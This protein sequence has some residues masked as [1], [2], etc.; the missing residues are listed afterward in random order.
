MISPN[1]EA[2]GDWPITAGTEDYVFFGVGNASMSPP[3]G[4][5]SSNGGM[6]QHRPYKW[7]WRRKRYKA[8]M[9]G[10]SSSQSFSSRMVH[11]TSAW[12][13]MPPT[14]SRK[15]MT[16]KTRSRDPDEQAGNEPC[17]WFS[18]PI[19]WH[20]VTRIEHG[21]GSSLTLAWDAAGRVGRN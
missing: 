12:S 14:R 2:A 9:H 10:P 17:P 20:A 13:T 5:S 3:A 6:T 8:G 19:R 1:L 11:T 4:P 16:R 7:T 21:E 18:H 15:R